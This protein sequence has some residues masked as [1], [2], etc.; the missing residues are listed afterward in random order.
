MKRNTM[1]NFLEETEE[2][3]SRLDYAWTDISWIG[4]EDLLVPLDQFISVAK[5]TNYDNETYGYQIAEDLVIVFKDGGW[6][7]RK[8]ELDR[9]ISLVNGGYECWE[10]MEPPNKPIKKVN[11]LEL[12]KPDDNCIGSY[13]LVSLCS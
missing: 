2:K 1:I 8:N 12:T 10:F 4:S 5:E 13:R 11:H 9:S 7:Y 3:M 6:L